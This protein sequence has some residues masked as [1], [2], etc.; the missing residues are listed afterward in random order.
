MI[1][2]RTSKEVSFS[3]DRKLCGVSF[4]L[5]SEM[6]VKNS[7]EAYVLPKLNISFL[8]QPLQLASIFKIQTELFCLEK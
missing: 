8:F 1:N 6:N 2:I 5:D 3:F 4:S 7:D